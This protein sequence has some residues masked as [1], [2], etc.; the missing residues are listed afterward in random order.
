[1]PALATPNPTPL[2]PLSLSVR[3]LVE[4][5]AESAAFQA[6]CGVATQAAAYARIWH[7]DIEMQAM[8]HFTGPAAVVMTAAFGLARIDPYHLRPDGCQLGLLLTDDDQFPRDPLASQT[9]FENWIGQVVQQIAA[10]QGT[11][12]RLT[13]DRITMSVPP[14]HTHP[15]DA[16]TRK[17]YWMAVFDVHWSKL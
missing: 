1:M 15:A 12:E 14:Q 5:V 4:L 6:R 2:G 11:G 7:P 3:K 8:A 16:G 17:P 9:D 10:I 13:I